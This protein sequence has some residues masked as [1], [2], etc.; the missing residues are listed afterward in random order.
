MVTWKEMLTPFSGKAS[1]E[2]SERE[3]F[4]DM[5]AEGG[6]VVAPPLEGV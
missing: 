5:I 4:Y 1:C 2:G 3:L 6:E